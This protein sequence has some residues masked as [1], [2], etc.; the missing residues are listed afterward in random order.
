MGQSFFLNGL[1]P[2]AYL[3]EQLP[4]FDNMQFLWRHF[5]FLTTTSFSK[6][7]SE[8]LFPRLEAWGLVPVILFLC[9]PASGPAPRDGRLVAFY[10][11]FFGEKGSCWQ[12]SSLGARI[13][14]RAYSKQ[15]GVSLN[16][17]NCRP[18]RLVK[19]CERGKSNQS[20]D[21]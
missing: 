9:A 21:R 2:T 1:Q 5:A 8:G 15:T 12:A 19:I 20:P 18:V 11:W 16:S 17:W 4:S 7:N 6:L 3:P 13:G 10:Q 14:K